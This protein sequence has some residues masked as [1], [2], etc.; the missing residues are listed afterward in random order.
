MADKKNREYT[1][2]V[3]E[4]LKGFAMPAAVAGVLTREQEMWLGREL[5][6]ISKMFGNAFLSSACARWGAE[7]APGALAK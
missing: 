3:R 4:S 2:A 5:M 6:G 1:K 7:N